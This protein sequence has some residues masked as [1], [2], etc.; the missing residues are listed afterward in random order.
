MKR[1]L[2]SLGLDP[3]EGPQTW[4]DFRREEEDRRDRIDAHINALLEPQKTLA[5]GAESRRREKWQD[6]YPPPPLLSPLN[7]SLEPP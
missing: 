1:L 5:R 3:T 7:A 4:E 2:T 6:D